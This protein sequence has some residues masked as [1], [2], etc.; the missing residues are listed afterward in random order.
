MAHDVTIRVPDRPIGA[1]DIVFTVVKDGQQFGRLKVSK[2]C[3]VWLPGRKS[4][5]YR[6]G[7]AQVD[8]AAREKGR[9]GSYPV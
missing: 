4:K 8:R 3:V 6:L 7:W 1:K 5:G 9:H 2:G